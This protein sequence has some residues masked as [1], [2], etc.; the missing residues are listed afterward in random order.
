[1]RYNLKW[2]LCTRKCYYYSEEELTSNS[3]SVQLLFVP[4]L[5]FNYTHNL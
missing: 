1:M 3:I 4:L 2:A 5:H